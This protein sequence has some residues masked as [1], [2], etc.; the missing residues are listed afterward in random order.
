MRCIIL[1][2][3]AS[4]LLLF[5]QRALS[6]KSKATKSTAPSLGMNGFR[7]NFTLVNSRFLCAEWTNPDGSFVLFV[8]TSDLSIFW[9]SQIGGLYAN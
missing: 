6:V 5:Y 7:A 1:L 4:S 9:L 8:F 3:A 2:P